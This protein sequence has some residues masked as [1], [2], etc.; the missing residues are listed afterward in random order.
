M[1]NRKINDILKQVPPDYYQKG[2]AS[3]FLQ[4][5]W[6]FNKLEQVVLGIKRHNASPKKI[7]DVGSAS[8]WFLNEVSH[9]F[10]DSKCVGID[11]YRDAIRYGK[12]K[13]KNL[14]LL[15]ADAHKLPF[16]NNTFD[17]VICCEVLE[18]VI[19][20]GRVLEEIRRVLKED[21]VVII[22]IDSGSWLFRF[23]W[24]WWTVLLKGV[25]R[26]A[27]L[28]SFSSSSLEKLF[29]KKKFRLVNKIFFNFNMA[30]IF[31]LVPVGS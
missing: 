12:I 9:R 11:V 27:H 10:P 2:V 29:S 3:N 28:H 6:H 16:N 24:F 18:H 13:Y 4:R 30:V 8:G 21:G 1:I 14:N 23:V 19:S 5:F 26:G 17:V 25:W 15:Y 7:L 20:A 31:S 22:E